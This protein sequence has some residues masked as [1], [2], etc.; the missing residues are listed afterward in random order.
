MVR[1][2]DDEIPRIF[3]AVMCSALS[4]F[5]IDRD[6]NSR[7]DSVASLYLYKTDASNAIALSRVF[8]SFS[9]DKQ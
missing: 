1:E 8:I 4:D 7:L 5:L 9:E 3:A 2:D 6:E